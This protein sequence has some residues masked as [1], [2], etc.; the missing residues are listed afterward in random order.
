MSEKTPLKL[1]NT[2][3]RKE[4][5]FKPI[6]KAQ[7]KMYTCGPTVYNYPHIGNYFAYLTSDFLKRTLKYNGFKVKQVMNITDV[8]DKTIRDSQVQNISLKQFTEKYTKAF[9]E[10]MRSLNIDTPELVPKATSHIKEMVSLIQ[11][12]LKKKIAYKGS[13]NSIYFSISKFRNY[14]KLSNLNLKELKT[15]RVKQ[16]EYT[17]DNAQ[18]FALW[19]A[20][21]SSDGNVFWKTSLGK[22]RPGWHIECSAMSMKYLGNHFDI[23]TGGIDLIFPHH[24]NEIAQSESSTKKKFV[25]YWIH[26][27]WIKVDNKKMSKSLGNFYTLRDL[28][29]L[30]FSPLHYRYLTLQTHYR[31]PLNFTLESQESAKTSYEKI[32]NKILSL[33]NQTHKGIDKTKEYNSQFISAINDDL[34]MPKALSIFLQALDDFDFSPKKKLQLLYKF[35]S[36]LG[37]K[38]KTFK[39]EKLTI[40]NEIKT[41][42]KE[43]ET[44]RKLKKFAE[45]DILRQR[46]LEKGYEI[47]DTQKGPKL[48]KII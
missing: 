4:E 32:K 7:V 41:M 45:A 12:L 10:D 24:E 9:L 21:D 28:I 47:S 48:S 8:D 15:T 39:P 36:V 33:K 23:H 16:D 40:P 30:G 14:G 43:R 18:D 13:D 22:G 17:K 37:L 25:N 27:E 3:T 11:D 34:N 29:N 42:L 19:K 1:Y 35:D 5:V 46:I 26:N 44:L 2:L 6:S 38:I 20:Y 31:K